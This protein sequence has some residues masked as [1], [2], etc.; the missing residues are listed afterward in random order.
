MPAAIALAPDSSAEPPVGAQP[1]YTVMNGVPVSPEILH[2]GIG[3]TAIAAA[4]HREADVVPL[5]S[6]VG[7]RSTAHGRD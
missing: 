3:V 5:H 4:S 2:Q 6:S 7:Q 1:L